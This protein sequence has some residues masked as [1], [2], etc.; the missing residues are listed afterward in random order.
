MQFSGQCQMAE[1]TPR[2]TSSLVFRMLVL[3]TICSYGGF[4]LSRAYVP[5]HAWDD[6]PELICTLAGLAIG[7]GVHWMLPRK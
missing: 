7:L 3:V 4:K 6:Y 2:S 1:K 5:I